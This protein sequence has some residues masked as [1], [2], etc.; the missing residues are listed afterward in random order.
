MSFLNHLGF[1]GRF[2]AIRLGLIVEESKI[3]PCIHGMIEE[4][5]VQE[6]DFMIL[7][8]QR[9]YRVDVGYFDLIITDYL[10]HEIYEFMDQWIP[11]IGGGGLLLEISE[12]SSN[13]YHAALPLLYRGAVQFVLEPVEV[14]C[15]GFLY[16]ND[17]H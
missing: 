9:V 2:Q 15:K 14:T 11:L 4:L 5:L 1:S 13:K 10:V 12:A 3:S 17:K 6:I 7:D 16:Q 8:V